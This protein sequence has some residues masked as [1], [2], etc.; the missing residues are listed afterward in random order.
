MR[1]IV[2]GG[3]GFIGS[4]LVHVLL[5]AGHEVLVI[6]DLSTGSSDNLDPRAAF[7]MLDILDERIPQVFAEFAPEAVIRV[8]AQASVPVSIKD[9]ERDRAV[10]AEGTR[11]VAAAARD[12]GAKRMLSASSAAVYGEPAEL[13]LRETS[14][15]EPINPYGASKLEAEGLL[16]AELRPAGVDYAS[17]RFANVYGPRQDAAGEGGVVAIFCDRVR[18]GERPVIYGD[19]EQTR[20]FVYVGDLAGA[21]LAMLAFEGSL[22]GDGGDDAAYNISTGTRTS[23]NEL[24][25]AVR[26]A[27]QY[28]GPVDNVDERAGDIVHSVLDPSHAEAVFGWRAGV[29]LDRG[30]SVTWNWFSSRR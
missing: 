10:N 21:M 11:R 8:P 2:T 3:A 12:A 23:V 18:A 25:M 24:V 29:T 26:T 30:M 5:G 1:I 19:G 15:K 14:R 16:E 27:A 9:P 17:M 20:D 7:R 22:A 28:F 13:P 4:N 6:D